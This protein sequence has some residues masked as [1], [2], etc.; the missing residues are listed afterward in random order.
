MCSRML[1]RWVMAAPGEPSAPRRRMAFCHR[2]QLLHTA[3]DD[4]GLCPSRSRG[5]GIARRAGPWSSNA[6]LMCRRDRSEQPPPTRRT[7]PMRTR[8]AGSGRAADRLSGRP[9]RLA[10]TTSGLRWLPP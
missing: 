4:L 9:E 10:P 6:S 2:F 5:D 8:E 1:L 7:V 3:Q